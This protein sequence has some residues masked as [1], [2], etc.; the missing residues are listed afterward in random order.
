MAMTVREVL[1]WLKT[2]DKNDSIAVDDGGLVGGV[3][4]CD[5]ESHWDGNDP[6]SHDVTLADGIDRLCHNC[7][8]HTPDGGL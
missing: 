2:L 5:T 3:P 4:L 1:A 7:R 6:T 8:K